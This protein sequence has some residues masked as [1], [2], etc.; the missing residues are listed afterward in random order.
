MYQKYRH[1]VLVMLFLTGFINYIDR[2]A[3]SI[4]APY[5]SKDFNLNA[6]ELIPQVTIR[7]GRIVYKDIRFGL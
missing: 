5:I 2:A 4:A 6:A 1:I 7:G 3:L